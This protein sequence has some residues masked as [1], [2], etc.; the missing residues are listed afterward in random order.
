MV[1]WCKEFDQSDVLI[2]FP[3]PDTPRTTRSKPA[4]IHLVCRYYDKNGNIETEFTGVEINDISEYFTSIYNKRF[5]LTE[6]EYIEGIKRDVYG[7]ADSY[8]ARKEFKKK[9]PDL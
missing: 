7:V 6:S 3:V 2:T 4:S 9:Y 1:E 5:T 8:M